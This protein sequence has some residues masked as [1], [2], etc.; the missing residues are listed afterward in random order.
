MGPVRLGC[1]LSLSLRRTTD[2]KPA[3]LR[4]RF[5]QLEPKGL[6]PVSKPFEAIGEHAFRI[7]P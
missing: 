3:L 7:A 5:G 6:D 4:Y 2:P 1:A